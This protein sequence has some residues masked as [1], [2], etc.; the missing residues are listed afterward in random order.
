[1]IDRVKSAAGSLRFW[2]L[3]LSGAI[4]AANKVLNI[5]DEVTL[6]QILTILIGGAAV[7]TVRPMGK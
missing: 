1:M 5:L 4:T 7:D 6:A 2:L 3:V